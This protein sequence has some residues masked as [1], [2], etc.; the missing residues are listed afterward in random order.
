M[1]GY[2]DISSVSATE[3]GDNGE[4]LQQ[5][6]NILTVLNYQANAKRLET[7]A[8]R[9]SD[10]DRVVAELMQRLDTYDTEI[11]DIQRTIAE[12]IETSLA[13]HS[14]T[15]KT[16]VEQSRHMDE[17][18]DALSKQLHAF[19]LESKRD[20]ADT[21]TR[22]SQLVE[23]YKEIHTQQQSL[24]AQTLQHQE[25]IHTKLD[26]VFKRLEDLETKQG[27]VRSDFLPSR[28]SSQRRGKFY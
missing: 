21:G 16:V 9:L 14:D 13:N 8:A 11:S 27:R 23:N 24:V 18:T 17:V 7:H 6:K 19:Q 15:H 5:T 25:D 2:S 20:R 26:Q 4:R 12:H 10:T 1:P 28:D 3:F 22:L